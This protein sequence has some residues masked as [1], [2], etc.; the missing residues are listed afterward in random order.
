MTNPKDI[1]PENPAEIEV[2]NETSETPIRRGLFRRAL[3]FNYGG[4][5][6]LGHRVPRKSLVIKH[7]RKG[8]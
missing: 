8:L 2:D 1:T 6:S 7:P 4:R 5:K 3:A